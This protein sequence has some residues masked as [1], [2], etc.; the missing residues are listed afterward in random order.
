MADRCEAAVAGVID[1]AARL[2]W[3]GRRGGMVMCMCLDVEWRG[4]VM[5]SIEGGRGQA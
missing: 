5:S 3:V 1:F 2:R 4:R